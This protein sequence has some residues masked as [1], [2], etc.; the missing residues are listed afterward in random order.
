[1]MKNLQKLA[2]LVGIAMLVGF[3]C[4]ALAAAKNEDLGI[5]V[6]NIV[7]GIDSYSYVATWIDKVDAKTYDIK[8]ANQC[9]IK[10]NGMNFAC[11]TK[12]NPN[13]KATCVKGICKAEFS[14]CILNRYIDLYVSVPYKIIDKLPSTDPGC[15]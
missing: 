13:C 8:L 7:C 6:S 14:R 2:L 5:K 9:Y 12:V 4:I 3:Q 15:K 11:G 1:M 10:A